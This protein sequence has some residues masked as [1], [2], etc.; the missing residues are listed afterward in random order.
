MQKQD[1]KK[2][3]E[4]DK[5]NAV[6][7]ATLETDA[8]D[9]DKFEAEFEKKLDLEIESK[10]SELEFLKEE[11]EKIANPEN[12]GNVIQNVVWDQFRDYIAK[13]A[14]EDFI[15]ENNGLPLDLSKSAHIQTAENFAEGKIATHNTTIDFQERYDNWQSNFQKDPNIEHKGGNFRFN[16]K[17]KVWEKYDSRGGSW[18]AV[19]NADARQDFDAGRPKGSTASGKQ[20]D[21][22][23][24][25][26]EIVRDPAANAFMTR[27]EQIAFANG[28]KNLNLM[29]AAANASKQDS[30]MGEWLDSERDGQTPSERFDI[31]EDELR[32]KDKAAREEFEALKE[33]GRSEAEESGKKSRFTEA[34]K[35]G[36]EA[37]RSAVLVLLANFV[38]EMLSKLVLWFKQKNKQWNTLID[39]MKL[40][41][42]SF[43]SKLTNI[44]REVGCVIASTVAYA[45]WEPIVGVIQKIGMILKQGWQSVKKAI[46]YLKDPKSKSEPIGIRILKVGEIITTGLAAVGAI[47]SGQAIVA[48]LRGTPLGAVELPLIGNL[49][50]ILGTL[51]GGLIF[52]I[53][54]AIIINFIEK[55]I[56]D[57]Q[58]AEMDAKIIEKGNEINKTQNKILAVKEVSMHRAQ[59]RM[60]GDIVQRHHDAGKA[61]GA[62]MQAIEASKK[63]IKDMNDDIDRML[64]N[65]RNNKER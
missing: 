12:L 5:E 44:L 29:D 48:G 41:I 10:L 55:Q 57:R 23:V 14:G 17:T 8:F 2:G 22:T 7:N 52:G 61:I 47:V 35:I 40:A 24:S 32:A 42:R 59:E 31:D 64:N 45:L 38:K 26:G 65:L 13:T 3:I 19:L 34:K 49:A 16:E 4:M 62:S 27:E 51:L 43:V 56:A 30:T 53:I 58:K 6:L 18:K 11:K 33:Q 20:M 54:G 21:H 28:E 63:H 46:E 25:A 39:H 15:K 9:F 37:L 1:V 50:D 60:H 36:K